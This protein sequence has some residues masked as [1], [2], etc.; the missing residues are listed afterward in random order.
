M[1][2]IEIG[3][4]LLTAVGIGALTWLVLTWWRLRAGRG[5]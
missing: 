2:Q 1:L 4:R 5:R 3:P